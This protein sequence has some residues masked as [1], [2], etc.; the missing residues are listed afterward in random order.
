MFDRTAEYV[1]M[2]E[3]ALRRK[4][5]ALFE[6]MADAGRADRLAVRADLV[7]HNAV[8]AEALAVVPQRLSR[9][10]RA[11]AEGVAASADQS[12]RAEIGDEHRHKLLRRK[13]LHMVVEFQLKHFVNAEKSFQ[14]VSA[15]V[16]RVDQPRI[17]A[18]ERRGGRAVERADGR[19]QTVGAS[20][21]QRFAKQR[22]VT[23]MY[24]VEESER[25]GV[26]HFSPP[27]KSFFAC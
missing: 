5:F 18:P 15:V 22:G 8:E 21:L 10:A 27:R 26:G 23:D 1:R 3:K 16:R 11:V 24:A 4:G 13:G 7:D 9:S 17:A 6:Q 14:D 12:A 25:Q 20:H 2:T 19:G